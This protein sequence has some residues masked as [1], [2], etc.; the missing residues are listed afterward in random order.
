MIEGEYIKVNESAEESD[1]TRRQM[2]FVALLYLLILLGFV[3]AWLTAVVAV[4]MNYLKLTDVRHT[5]L[6]SHYRWQLRTFWYGLLWLIIGIITIP[7]L[8]LGY[9]VLFI[10]GI[11][12]LYRIVKGWIYLYERKA[13]LL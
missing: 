7:L 2:S 11:W 9:I 8:L 10:N 6:A 3:T 13:I 4:I 1:D 12:V 5:W